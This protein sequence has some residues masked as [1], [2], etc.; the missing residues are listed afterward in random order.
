M[1]GTVVRLGWVRSP[2]SIEV[3][4]GTS[5]AGAVD[6]PLYTTASVDS[7]CRPVAVPGF[8]RGAGPPRSR[9]RLVHSLASAAASRA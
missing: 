1:Y 2:Q 9:C 5:R 4:F 6:V 8:T 7:G 3:R